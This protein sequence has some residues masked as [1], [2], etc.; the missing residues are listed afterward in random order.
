MSTLDIVIL[1]VIGFG[2]IKG[3]TRGFI[4]ESL[5]F[6][7][8]FLGIFLALELT[9]PVSE[10]LFQNSSFFELISILIFIALFI[11]LSISIKLGAKLLKNAV[12]TTFFGT[13]DNVIGAIAGVFKWMFILSIMIWVFN[14]VGFDVEGRYAADAII[15]PYIVDIGPEI[16]RSLSSILTFIQ[17]LIDSLENMTNESDRTMTYLVIT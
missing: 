12:D 11:L 10:W 3:Y 14:A 13:L 15:F 2:A 9:V 4:V 8:F 17:D 7:A 16:F 5:S 1:I 6:L